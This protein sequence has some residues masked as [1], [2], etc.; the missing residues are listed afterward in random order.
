MSLML[1]LVLTPLRGISFSFSLS[2]E[3]VVY[4]LFT[5]VLLKRKN[6]N[7]RVACI[8]A[9]ILG[10][11]A[12]E[13]PFRVVNFDSCLNSFLIPICSI[14]GVMAAYYCYKHKYLH[15]I[16]GI[17]FW[18][19]CVFEGQKKIEDYMFFGK[20]SLTNLSESILYNSLNNSVF[21]REMK[22]KYLVLDFWNANCGIC[23]KKFP[24]FQELYNKYN[25]WADI[26]F[27]S[28]FVQYRSTENLVSGD[29]ILREKGY[30]FPTYATV[31]GS[32]LL[33]KSSIKAYPTI[34]ILDE[35]RTI[36][37]RGNLEGALHKIGELP[38]KR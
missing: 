15:V 20:Y 11:T 36:I 10:R 28:V 32:D 14:I 2:I 22:S 38:I 3:P 7:N 35:D 25:G 24:Q 34:L 26:S 19:Y 18:L 4:F 16:I 5:Y 30:T 27:F 31:K 23:Y 12:L 9:I 29:S 13:V 1:F 33:L 37:Y 8:M 21:L 6:C 17:L